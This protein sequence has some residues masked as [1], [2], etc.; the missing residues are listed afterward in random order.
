M[1]QA[2][3]FCGEH[4]NITSS[5]LLFSTVCMLKLARRMAREP[6]ILD[7]GNQGYRPPNRDP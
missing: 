6:T 4:S 3:Q 1:T 2:L 7:W 5:R